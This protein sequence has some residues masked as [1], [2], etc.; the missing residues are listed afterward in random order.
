M[1]RAYLTLLPLLAAG[2]LLGGCI[3]TVDSRIA[4][5]A[6]K[7]QRYSLPLPVMKVEPQSDGTMTVEVLYL[8]DPNNTYTVTASSILGSYTLDVKT[9]EGLL[10]MVSFSPNGMAV[11]EQ[12]ATSAGNVEKARIDARS[13]ADEAE[14]KAAEATAKVISDVSTAVAT[15][16]AKLDRLKELRDAGLKVT[17]E[18]IVAA[19]VDLAVAKAKLEGLRPS[20]ASFNKAANQP[21]SSSYPTAAG[22][23]FFAMV[24]G[25]N[26][27]VDLV[28]S[29]PQVIGETSF[30]VPAA[31]KPKT[32]VYEVDG[33][34]VLRLGGNA[35]ELRLKASPAPKRVIQE[36]VELREASGRVLEDF[37][38]FVTLGS[39]DGQSILTVTFADDTPAG[40]YQLVIPVIGPDDTKQAPASVA[41]LIRTKLGP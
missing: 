12:L 7:G 40:K 4:T 11:A 16:Q 20:T 26:G 5:D 18:Q 15:A 39:K 10:D 1:S 3:T 2:L 14:A 31:E 22:P 23:L 28:A 8:P 21:G 34:A 9:K 32:V 6:A 17:E 35:L 24:P 29:S 25:G 27:T 36:D 41:V 33:S 38:P 37:Q 19:E 30:A 13:K